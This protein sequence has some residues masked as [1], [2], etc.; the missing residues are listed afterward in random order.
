M[1]TPSLAGGI[2][3]DALAGIATSA[4]RRC[5]EAWTIVR[6]GR[7]QAGHEAGMSGARRSHGWQGPRCVAVDAGTPVLP[8]QGFLRIVAGRRGAQCA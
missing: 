7:L 2:A 6:S 4:A 8:R 1:L 5:D 3:G